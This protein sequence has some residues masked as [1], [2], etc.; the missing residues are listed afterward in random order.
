VKD[1]A[2]GAA[3]IV[4]VVRRRRYVWQVR[5]ANGALAAACRLLV[6]PLF[7][8]V[9]V[10]LAASRKAA[11]YSCVEHVVVAVGGPLT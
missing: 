5:R 10:L 4:C 3:L 2:S 1:D 6:W 7:C 9:S 11:A 8:V